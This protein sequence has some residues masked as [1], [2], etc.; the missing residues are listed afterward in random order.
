ME[1]IK[2]QKILLT[3]PPGCGKSTLIERL[4]DKIRGP[5]RG[6][7]TRELRERGRRVGFALAALDGTTGLL[8]HRD[9]KSRYRVGKYGVKVEDVERIAV[10]AITPRRPEEVVVIDEIG[11][12]ECFSPLFREAVLKVLE[13]EHRV[14]G[15]IARKGDR[16][17]E[18]LKTR[19]GVRVV[20]VTA[21]NREEL[22][23]LIELGG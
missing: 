7:F 17:I 23:D 14:L 22:V 9:L 10:P 4:A 13:S 21:A 12:M 8:A 18:G 5:K 15:S 1:R 20:E 19:P 6:F 2:A 16:F 3:G 11:K